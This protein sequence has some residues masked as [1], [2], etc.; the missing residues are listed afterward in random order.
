MLS[1]ANEGRRDGAHDREQSYQNLLRLLMDR[2]QVCPKKES[3]LD[4]AF[5]AS[6]RVTQPEA[7]LACMTPGIS[8]CAS[9]TICSSTAGRGAGRGS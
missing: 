5:H 9:V 2:M 4:R 6:W 8:K 1:P 3:Y 7:D